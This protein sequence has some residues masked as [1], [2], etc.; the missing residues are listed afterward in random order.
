MENKKFKDVFCGY[1]SSE[2]FHV[3]IQEAAV[4]FLEINQSSGAVIIRLAFSSL[5]DFNHIQAAE[6]VISNALDVSVTIDPRFPSDSLDDACFPTIMALLN[7]HSAAVNGTFEG[8]GCHIENGKMTITLTHGGLNILKT[9]KTD[10]ILVQ[11]V[12][13]HF[14]CSIELCFDGVT[15]VDTESDEYRRLME[16]ADREV[17]LKAKEA[18]ATRASQ[19]A[20]SKPPA[21]EPAKPGKPA[22]P[23]RPPLDGLPIYL[24]TAQMVFGS[25]IRELPTPLSSLDP[26]GG[27]YTVWGCVFDSEVRTFRDGAKLRYTYKITDKTSSI[28]A[29]LWLDV[30]RDKAKIVALEGVKKGTCVLMSGLYEFDRFAN[31]N[32][33]N[34]KGIAVVAPYIKQDNAEH[35]RVELHL[36]TK[37]SSMDAVS[38]AESLVMRAA[39]WGH[40][41]IAITDHGV[42]QAFPEAMNAASKAQKQGKDIKILYGVEAYYIN[43]GANIVCG[44]ATEPL[45]GKFVVFDIETTGLSVQNERITE[46]GAV[47]FKNG[48]V[49]D[50]FNTFVNPGK[51]ISEKITQLTGINDDMVKDAPD[52]QQALELFYAFCGETE[53]LVAHNAPFDTSFIKAAAKRCKLPYSFTSLDTVPICRAL[54]P[55]LKNHKLDTVARYV[56]YKDFNHHRALDDAKALCAVFSRLITDMKEQKNITSV[57][58]INRELAGM[59]TKKARP[60]HLIILVKNKVG[61]KN[62]YKLISWSHLHNFYRKPR[63]TKTKLLEHREGLIIGSACEQGELFQAILSDKSWGE[64]CDVAK[65]YD[66]LE[67]QPISNNEFM[68]RNGT[69]K[70]KNQLRNFNRTIIRLGEKVNIP[71]C[72]TCDV[73]FMDPSDEVYRRILMAGQGFDDADNQAQLFFRT[74][75]EMLKEFEYLGKEK[76]YEVVIENP[77]QIADLIESIRPI[78][79]GTFPP[80]IDGAEEQLQQ[81]TWNRAKEIYGDDVPKIVADRLERE[82]TSI[83]KHGFAVLY[84]IAQK[85]VQDSVEHGYLVGSR[86]SVGSSFV[87]NMAGIS[88]VN[89]LPPHYVCKKCKHSEFFLKGEVGSGFDLPEKACPVCGELLERDGHEIPFETFLGFDGDKAPDIDLNFAG[90]YQANAHR[91]TESLFGSDHVFKAGTIATIADK[92]AFGYVKKYTEERGL[93]PSNAEID[94][95]LKGCTGIKRTTGQHPGGMVVVPNE[96]DV[97]DFT[98]IQRPADDMNSDIKTTHFDFHSIHDTILKLDNLGHDIPTI[99][100]YLEEYTGISVMDVPMSDPKIYKLFTSPE[101]LGV[102]EEEIECNTGTLSIPEM[103]TPFVRQMLLEAKPKNFADLLQISGLSHG[104]DVWLGNAQDLIRSRICTISEVIGTRDSIMTYLIHKGLDNKMA[105][106]IM[107]IVRKGNAT[108]LLNEEHFT[109]MKKHNVPQWY[110]DSCMKIKYMF[111]KAHAAA[112]CIA[113]LRVAWYKVYRPAEYYAA[114]FTVRSDDFDAEPVM[115]GKTEVKRRMDEIRSKGKEAS[116]KEQSQAETLHIVYEA[117]TRGIVFLTVDLYKSHSYKFLMENGQIRLP[118]SSIKGLGVAAAQGLLEARK[119]GDFISCDDLQTRSGISKT[120]VESL[121]QLGALG[122]LPATSQITFFGL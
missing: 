47:K 106:K 75:D 86:G 87:A 60:Y 118:F 83:I 64:L 98:P 2:A 90:E 103:G 82:L 96:Y 115:K 111:P 9:T 49:I 78:P 102:T 101:P 28:M 85:L 81:I 38:D 65:F 62:L 61:L 72:A 69:A 17:A 122:D 117:M 21:D 104:T 119:A 1:I 121:R 19:A 6:R 66:F 37:M 108:K 63:I 30:K 7:R 14:G 52:E 10:R 89:P 33:L 41:A 53:V 97:E 29:I 51:S 39:E 32:I 34:P 57:D 54:F 13:T 70:D 45:D 22:D 91:Y 92:T 25:P 11:L 4:Q 58:A 71:V 93:T 20:L 68:I 112:Y 31:D 27:S 77:N 107:E 80:H 35:K 100:K 110:V 16:E 99:Y 18:A 8:A 44:S 76:A 95:L 36:H 15:D 12:Q 50:C 74:T 79:K 55:D 40:K 59:D 43:D 23:S 113:A 3:D 114:Y 116:A 120:V 56:G 5:V 88:E 26:Y 46:I 67:I 24:E 109:A 94:R 105:F 42:V 48:E 84:M 73:H